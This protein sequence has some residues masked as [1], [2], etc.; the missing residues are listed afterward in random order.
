VHLL[1]APR[2]P[3]IWVDDAESGVT[4]ETWCG[5]GYDSGT[6]CDDPSCPV[7]IRIDRKGYGLEM[8]TSAFLGLAV[9]VQDA[10]ARGSGRAT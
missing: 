10:L 6:V 5:C 4:A 8:R 7:T 2:K 3:G 1:M 9:K